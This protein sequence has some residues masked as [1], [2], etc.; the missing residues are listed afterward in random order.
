MLCV[1]MENIMGLEE[2]E[3]VEGL[4][5]VRLM[6]LEEKIFDVFIVILKY[7]GLSMELWVVGGWVCDKV[8]L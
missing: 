6:E 1:V 7:F 5:I 8:N 3:E 4:D 2:E